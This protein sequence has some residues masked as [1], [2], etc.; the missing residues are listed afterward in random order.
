MRLW[1]IHPK[2][3]DTKGLVALWRESLLAKAVLQS[4]TKGYTKHPQLERFKGKPINYINTFLKTIYSESIERDHSF[5]KR[6]IGRV[7]TTKKLTISSGQL[8]YEFKHLKKKLKTRDKEKYKELS[9]TKTIEPNL[10]FKK[11]PGRI[12]SWEKLDN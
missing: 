5:D 10:L 9:K 3:L 2:Y 4:K 7:F 11:V 12:A 1:S 8:D 6:K